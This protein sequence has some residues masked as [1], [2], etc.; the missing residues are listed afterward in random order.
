VLHVLS[1]EVLVAWLAFGLSAFVGG[2]AWVH[3]ARKR[4][5][6]VASSVDAGAAVHTFP[7]RAASVVAPTDVAVPLKDQLAG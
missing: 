1:A 7:Q 6:Q 4:M 2:V 5:K 3:G